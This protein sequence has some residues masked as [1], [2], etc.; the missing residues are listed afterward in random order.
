MA[1]VAGVDSSTQSCKVLIVDADSGEVVRE[2]RANHPDGTAVDPRHWWTAFQQALEQAGGLRG[3]EALSVGGQQHGMVALDHDGEVI[4][5]ALLWNDT[6]SA[7]AALQLRAEFTDWAPAVGHV[8]LASFTNSKV[9]WLADNEPRNAERVA[10]LALPH[11]WLTWKIRG[12][13]ELSDLITDRSDASGTGYFDSVSNEYRRD[14]L[15]L[16]LRRDANEIIL[17]RVLEPDESV[18]GPG[19]IVGPG[20][21]DNAM[22]ALGMALGAGHASLSIGT[23]G[24]VAAVAAEP[25]V[26][27]SGVVNGF[28]D[29]RGEWLALTATLNAARVANSVRE[30]LGVDFDEFSELALSSAPGAGGLTMVPWFEGERTPNLPHAT[31]SLMG[32]TLENFDRANL[33]RAS[34]EGMLCLLAGG[35]QAIRELGTTIDRVALIGGGSRSEAVRQLA[36]SVLGLPVDVPAAAEYVA[37]G[38][39]RQAAW[40]LTGQLPQWQPEGSRSYDGEPSPNLVSNYTAISQQLIDSNHW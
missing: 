39:A 35:L 6:R 17:P 12:S 32:M 11:D 21:G 23:S 29:C 25:V 19:F 1:L 34:V 10:A 13:E 15:G 8:P 26:D 27:P 37:L 7:D 33:A 24:V 9:R 40:V 22:A 16:C 38:A 30:L 28:A 2:G 36:P 4:R 20:G 5:D 31:A 3:V 14:L 18:Q